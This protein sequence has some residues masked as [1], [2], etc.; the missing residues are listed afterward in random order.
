MPV[1]LIGDPLL[2]W[3]M[4]AFPDTGS[5]RQQQRTLNFRLSSARVIVEHAYGRLKGRW[6]CLLKRIDI[7]VRDVPELVTACTVL[8]EVRSESFDDEWLNGVDNRTRASNTT[9]NYT[10]SGVTIREA[11]M[12]YFQEH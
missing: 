12:A 8:H 1:V 4:K 10:E 11:F 3:L 9:I 6:R 7:N 5:L 2:S